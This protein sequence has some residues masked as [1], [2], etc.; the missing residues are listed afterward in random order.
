MTACKTASVISIV[1]AGCLVANGSAQDRICGDAAAP[2]AGLRRTVYYTGKFDTQMWNLTTPHWGAAWPAGWRFEFHDDAALEASILALDR[3][4]AAAGVANVSA[5]F[6]A[7]RPWAFRADLW[8]YCILWC[9]HA[10]KHSITLFLQGLRRRLPG[11][12]DA[13]ERRRRRLR[14]RL[15][16]PPGAADEPQRPPLR[17]PRSL[18]DVRGPSGD[19]G[20]LERCAT[21]VFPEPTGRPRRLHDVDAVA[22][23]PAG[24]HSSRRRHRH[25]AALSRGRQSL[26]VTGPGALGRAAKARSAGGDVAAPC[27]WRAP[28][29]FHTV[30]ERTTSPSQDPHARIEN[31][32]A[33]DGALRDRL[34]DRR[35]GESN[36]YGTF[37]KNR[38]IYNPGLR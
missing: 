26:Y 28:H 36:Y 9:V 33:Q 14:R 38:D 16:G 19:A 12:Q 29:I 4:L 6:A 1:L 21:G 24:D 5:A 20:P 7:L 34:H 31:L 17:L 25:G 13:P 23:R 10:L 15:R 35:H 11:L 37:W 27:G 3:R 30:S 22:P 2:T 8:R 18:G 32:F